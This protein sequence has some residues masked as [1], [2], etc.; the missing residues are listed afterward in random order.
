[1]DNCIAQLQAYLTVIERDLALLLCA[2]FCEETSLLCRCRSE[3]KV[4][5]KGMY[6]TAK[7]RNAL[8]PACDEKA[9][10]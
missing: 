9:G 8:D 10:R 1:M 7:S 6:S 5:D 2:K 4:V 3:C